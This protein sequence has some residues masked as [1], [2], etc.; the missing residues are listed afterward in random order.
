MFT[1]HKTSLNLRTR[2]QNHQDDGFWVPSTLFLD[3]P[4][5]GSL[6]QT[7]V[8]NHIFILKDENQSNIPNFGYY[9]G[10]KKKSEIR[11]VFLYF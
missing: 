5:F 2:N 11:R 1:E 3:W 9:W 6:D 7:S 4:K 10:F 8:T